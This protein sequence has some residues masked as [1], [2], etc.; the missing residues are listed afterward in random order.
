MNY[1]NMVF[2]E[3]TYKSQRD[4]KEEKFDLIDFLESLHAEVK[5]QIAS[6]GY[7]TKVDTSIVKEEKYHS[8]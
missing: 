1:I 5:A 2:E 7:D 3:A 4:V 8:R 6:M